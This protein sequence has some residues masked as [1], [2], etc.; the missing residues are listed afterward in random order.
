MSKATTHYIQKRKRTKIIHYEIQ[1]LNLTN[2]NNINIIIIIIVIEH[3][4]KSI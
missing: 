2:P 4:D 3:V 1:T